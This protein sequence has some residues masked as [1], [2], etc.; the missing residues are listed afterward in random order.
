MS[1]P[2]PVLVSGV[3]RGGLIAFHLAASDPRVAAV[4]A[5]A[6]VTDLLAL[7]EFSG[8][9]D[10]A[11]VRNA[12]ALALVPRL[13]D[14]AVLLTINEDDARVSTDACRA[15]FVALRQSP[16]LHQL[17]IDPGSGHSVPDDTYAAGAAWLLENVHSND[18]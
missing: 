12:G 6:P 16:E 3:S 10:S 17:R 2:G 9:A 4:A 18:R 7:H 15:F 1:N 14:R 5:F 8:L 13:R 11:A